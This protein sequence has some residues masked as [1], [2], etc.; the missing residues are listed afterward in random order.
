[1]KMNKVIAAA[2]SVLKPKPILTISDWA[3]KYR[4]IARG[5]GPEP[6]LWKTSR[7]PYT[8]E[9][10]D[11]FSTSANIVVVMASSQVGKTEI[12]LNMMGYYMAEDPSPI[13]Y[14][15]PTEGMA[16]DFSKT[17]VDPTITAC[18]VLNTLFQQNAKKTDNTIELK[19]FPSGYLALYGASTPTKLASKPI[20]VLIADEVDRYPRELKGEGDPLK[21]ALQRTTNF[22]NR[23]VLIISTPTVKETSTIVEWFDKSDKRYYNVPCPHCNTY[24]VLNWDSM[25]WE[26][27][28]DG[29]YIKDS[30]HLECPSCEGKIYDGHKEALLQDGVWIKTDL[31]KNI[32]GFHISSLYSSW[33]TFEELVNEY[34]EIADSEDNAK[35]REFL[36]LKLG[37]PF[38]AIVE[39]LDIELLESHKFEYDAELPEGVLYLTC[40]VDVQDNRLEYQILGWGENNQCWVITNQMIIGSPEQD[41]VWDSLDGVICRGYSFADGRKLPIS[42]SCVD[43]GYLADR[44]YKFTTPREHLRV[45]AV[46]GFGGE[47][48][49]IINNLSSKNRTYT[50]VMKVGVDAA[51][52]VIYARLRNHTK[53]K[54]YIHFPLNITHGCGDE[55]YKQLNSERRVLDLKHGVKRFIWKKIRDRNEAL[56]TFV[57][58]LA[59]YEMAAPNLEYI[60]EQL[61][62]Q[63]FETNDDDDYAD[64][65]ENLISSGI[66]LY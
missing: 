55:Y 60:K 39:D 63:Q 23:K 61:A 37:E 17:R 62:N 4:Y 65:E 58:A 20:R 30:A 47:G 42:A 56:D 59:A 24:I 25:K 1:M 14:L 12:A 10:M 33:V 26:T 8:K 19:T 22:W 34:I 29:N 9:I 7:A 52:A 50:K 5:T 49:P 38:E 13:M 54:N 64:G 15:M 44:V 48:I 43:S 27:D 21:L 40:G 31:N 6:G 18:K 35:M 57:Y 53:G 51:K 28:S 41:D 32:P 2:L 45:A 36:N 16:S 11:A 66:K 3:D 46:K